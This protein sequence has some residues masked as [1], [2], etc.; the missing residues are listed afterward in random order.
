MCS[1]TSPT[2]VKE[3]TPEWYSDPA[4]LTNQQQ[5]NLGST[6]DG[7]QITDVILPPW[8]DNNADKFIQV[9]RNA[10]ESDVCSATLPAWIDLIFGFKQK[11]I[12]AQKANN[13]FYHLT[14]Y[15]PEDLARI[16]DED[17]RTEVELHIADFGHCPLHL[18]SHPHPQ[19]KPDSVVT[20]SKG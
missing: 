1:R 3:L 20:Q 7:Q 13:L 14:Y 2:E 9:M 18:F 17:L 4:F 8:A 11:G 6:V 16:E 10:L 19:R 15:E 12:E 5:F